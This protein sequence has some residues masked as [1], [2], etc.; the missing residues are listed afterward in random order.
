MVSE[1]V[2]KILIT[3]PDHMAFSEKIR[4]QSEI[5]VLVQRNIP[6]F[7][8]LLTMPGTLRSA[9]IRH[10]ALVGMARGHSQPI[11]GRGAEGFETDSVLLSDE[12]NDVN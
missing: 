7:T 9:R 11:L 5:R 4:Y 10:T 12:S 2:Q 6:N 3:N 8:D 1:N